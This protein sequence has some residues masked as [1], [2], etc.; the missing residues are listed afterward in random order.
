MRLSVLDGAASAFDAE[1]FRRLAS[2][3]DVGRAV[4]LAR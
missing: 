1:L 2:G 3:E 4:T